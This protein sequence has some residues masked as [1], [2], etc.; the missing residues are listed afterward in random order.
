M[1]YLVTGAVTLALLAGVM[2]AGAK[3]YGESQ[4]GGADES[5]YYATLMQPDYPSTSCCGEADVYYADEQE[6]GPDGTVI[7]IITDTRPDERTLPDGRVIK[8]QH[9]PVGTKVL[10][11]K[12]KMRKH[13]TPNPTGHTIIFLAGTEGGWIVYCYEPMPLL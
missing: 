4:Y 8:R 1:Y 6:E 2:S 10:V 5:E 11:P 13:Y 9:I 12:Y 3:T 7:A